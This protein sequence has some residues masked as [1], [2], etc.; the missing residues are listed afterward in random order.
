MITVINEYTGML[1]NKP[2]KEIIVSS[3][4]ELLEVEA[5]HGSIGYV[6]ENGKVYVYDGENENWIQA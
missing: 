3:E 6:I 2:R 5:G 4:E 1:A